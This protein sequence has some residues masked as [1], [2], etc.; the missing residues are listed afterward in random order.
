[1]HFTP[2]WC[3]VRMRTWY[4]HK[5]EPTNTGTTSKGREA[6]DQLILILCLCFIK[7]TLCSCLVTDFS[8][9]G[10]VIA[11][12]LSLS[13]LLMMVRRHERK[14]KKGK[15]L[16]LVNACVEDRFTEST[17]NWAC[18]FLHWPWTIFSILLLFLFLYRIHC[19]HSVSLPTSTSFLFLHVLLCFYTHLLLETFYSFASY[20]F[21]FFLCHF[22]PC[23]VHPVIGLFMRCSIAYCCVL[24]MKPHKRSHSFSP[25]TLLFSSLPL[26]LVEWECIFA[27]NTEKTL[28]SCFV[29]FSSS[30]MFC[31]W[32]QRFP[33]HS[34][35]LHGTKMLTMI[36]IHFSMWNDIVHWS[37]CLIGNLMMINLL[38]PLSLQRERERETIDA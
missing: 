23:R 29:M 32:W 26:L 20:T 4:T 2:F 14:K 24:K 5:N 38:L 28:P 31:T 13:A 22:C 7:L 34:T 37:D 27:L 8:T 15:K 18:K 17:C 9:L 33:L 30:S 6:R 3:S 19:V 21:Q 10:R 35:C 16:M 11:R 25:P 1:M 12:S 36:H